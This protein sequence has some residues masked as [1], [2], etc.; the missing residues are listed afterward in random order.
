MRVLVIVRTY[1]LHSLF[2]FNSSKEANDWNWEKIK[3]K[4]KKVHIKI[5]Y[6][7]LFEFISHA[8]PHSSHLC[9]VVFILFF[10]SHRFT[11]YLNC[12]SDKICLFHKMCNSRAK[13]MYTDL[14]L[15]LSIFND[16]GGGVFNISQHTSN[17]NVIWN[18]T[19]IACKILRLMQ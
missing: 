12:G 4:K 9:V 2:T 7:A 16:F 14:Y 8:S 6:I 10:K 15:Y 19:I 18:Q 13:D 1:T 17:Y 3:C 5:S 11:P